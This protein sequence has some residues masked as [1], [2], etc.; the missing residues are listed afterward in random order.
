[1]KNQA[2]QGASAYSVQGRV[3]IWCEGGC[4]LSVREYAGAYLV[5]T[6]SV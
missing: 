2:D 5:G 1:M 6:Y 4:L 3:L